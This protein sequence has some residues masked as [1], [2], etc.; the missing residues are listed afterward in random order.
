[1]VMRA[2][3][4][5]RG[6][7]ALSAALLLS[8]CSFRRS[9]GESPQADV[10]ADSLEAAR[11]S[12]MGSMTW[13]E[14]AALSGAMARAADDAGAAALGVS[15]GLLSEDGAPDRTQ[16]KVVELGDGTVA[17]VRVA[18]YRRGELADGSAA[19]LTLAFEDAIAFRGVTDSASTEGGW[20]DSSLRGWLNGEA[21]DLLPADL[22]SVVRPAAK[23]TVSLLGEA[24]EVT[25]DALW[26]FSESELA[27]WADGAPYPELADEGAA[28]Q[29][30]EASPA[31]TEL[32]EDAFVRHDPATG[33]WACW[34]ERTVDPSPQS[35]TFVFRTYTGTRSASK[36]I[37][38]GPNFDLGVCPGFCI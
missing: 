10:V 2:G 34:W 6:F 37:D 25:E 36:T 12:A 1:M 15:A 30:F 19:G 8:S 29:L 38:Y 22:R 17:R 14:L 4:T 31:G 28:Y 9:D 11:S 16:A 21:L 27:G 23:R 26:L 7:V 3:I 20:R 35:D 13:E 32:F 24:A 33:A 5:R 18:G